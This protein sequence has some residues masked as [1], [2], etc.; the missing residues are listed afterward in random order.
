M[1]LRTFLRVSAL[2]ALLAQVRS[3]RNTVQASG[4]KR[5][6]PLLAA[7]RTGKVS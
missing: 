2:V 7:G 1:K 3:A 5:R 6:E 4:A